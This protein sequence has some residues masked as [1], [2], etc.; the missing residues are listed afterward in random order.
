MPYSFLFNF[1]SCTHPTAGFLKEAKKYMKKVKNQS[2]HD[3]YGSRSKETEK[4][5]HNFKP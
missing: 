5:D 1:F 2:S 3:D 4:I